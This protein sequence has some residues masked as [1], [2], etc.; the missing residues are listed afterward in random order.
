MLYRSTDTAAR[1]VGPKLITDAVKAKHSPAGRWRPSANELAI[2]VEDLDSFREIVCRR[3]GTVPK[4]NDVCQ[5][6]IWQLE[7]GIVKNEAAEKA[8]CRRLR[9]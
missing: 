9:R 8:D 1:G 4:N 6:S 2:G 3:Y 7:R 5:L